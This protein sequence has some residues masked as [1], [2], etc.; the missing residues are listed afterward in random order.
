[1]FISNTA[2]TAMM[3]PIGKSVVNLLQKK[4]KNYGIL[5]DHMKNLIYQ[6]E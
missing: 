1:M 6:K 3:L 5:G 2:T 4:D